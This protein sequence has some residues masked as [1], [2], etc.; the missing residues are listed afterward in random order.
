VAT[1]QQTRLR[2][3]ALEGVI[4]ALDERLRLLGV[5][6]LFANAFRNTLETTASLD[7]DGTTFVITGD[8]PAMWLRDS[9]GQVLPYL[10]FCAG[11]ALLRRLVRGVILRQAR[12][13]R[14]DPY[15]NAFTREPRGRAGHGEDAT[16]QRPGV[17]ERKWEV[18]SLCWPLR[19]LRGYVAATGDRAVYA[20]EDVRGALAAI[21]E[22]FEA[23]REHTTR[24]RYSFRRPRPDLPF[25][26]TAAANPVAPTGMI[27]GAF[28]P[29]DDG[30]A[31]NYH[32]PAQMFAVVELDHLAGIFDRIYRAPR[33]AE[34]CRDLAA[35]VDRG[36]QRH[37]IV[38]HPRAGRIY[39]YEVDGLGHAHLMDDANLPSLLGIP[40]IGYRP[41]DD[42]IYLN[43]RRFALSP[44]NPYHFRG[45]H[46][47]AVGSPHTPA[48]Y[49]W[50]MALVVQA[51]TSRSPGEVEALLRLLGATDGGTGHIHES[52]DPDDP[53]RYTRAWFAWGNAL[54]AELVLRA[55][56]DA[57]AR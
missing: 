20:E 54:F 40:E 42:P 44:A 3:T 18:D 5:D 8:I 50:P 26:D 24:S 16:E 7:P 9:T 49:V 51:L 10:R 31:Y 34:R 36:I 47:A 37:G 23:E 14:L 48:P 29:S 1:A 12:A 2:S 28:R 11:D 45:R 27:W 30:C 56:H 39:A 35:S 13:I 41:A 55:H 17:W 33:W 52:F 22:T 19:L 57:P 43:T 25:H 6:R 38:E 4:A 53:R 32:I 21:L 46:A 15:A